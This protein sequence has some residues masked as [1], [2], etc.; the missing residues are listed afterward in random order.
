VKELGFVEIQGMQFWCGYL[1][2][3]NRAAEEL[4][5]LKPCPFAGR[6]TADRVKIALGELLEIWPASIA[7]DV[8]AHTLGDLAAPRKG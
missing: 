2:S 1:N 4:A 7:D 3:F 8:L 5:A 6:V